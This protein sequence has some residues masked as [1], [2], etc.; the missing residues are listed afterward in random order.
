MDR[1]SNHRN[2]K[3]AIE[4][5]SKLISK[6][7]WDRTSIELMDCGFNQRNNYNAMFI[8]IHKKLANTVLWGRE[9]LYS[10]MESYITTNKQARRTH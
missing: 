5:T 7:T 4:I 9:S 2:H 8:T 6:S 10:T 1:G 3:N